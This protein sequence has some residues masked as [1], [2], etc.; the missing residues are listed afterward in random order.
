MS[1]VLVVGDLHAP[2]VHPR[3]LRHC[4]DIGNKYKCNK[5]VLTGDEA[6]NHAISYHESNPDGYSAGDELAQAKKALGR[7][8]TSFPVAS[9]C[10]SNHGSLFYRKGVTAGL[11]AEVFR[12]YAEIWGAPKT[13]RWETRFDIDQV[14]YIHGTGFSGQNGA[15]NAAKKHR[16]STVIGHIHSHGG[17]LWSASH[18][19]IIFGLNAGCGIDLKAYAFEYGREFPERPTLGCG[20]VLDGVKAIFEPMRMT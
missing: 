4:I 9:V 3:Y 7:W 1:R 14:Q 20:V 18:K 8:F 5:V 13:W 19:D 10:I 17:V 2:F 16:Q 11:P 12:S 15:I 6:D